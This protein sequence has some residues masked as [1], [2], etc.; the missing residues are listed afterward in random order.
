[1]DAVNQEDRIDAASRILQAWGLGAEQR[2]Q[3]LDQPEQA[4]VIISI[5]ESLQVMFSEDKERADA[6]PAKPNA[7]FDGKPALDVMLA[8]DI[9]RVR[10]YLKYHVYNS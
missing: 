6:W 10:E 5:Y 4:I 1:M 8:G 3:L 2:R 7:D 9:K